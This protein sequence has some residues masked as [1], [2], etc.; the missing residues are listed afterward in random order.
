[1]R[2]CEHTGCDKPVFGTDK[3]TRTGYCKTHQYLR[4]DIDKDTIL[5][6][7][8]KKQRQGAAKSVGSKLRSGIAN[9]DTN[10]KMALEFKSKSELMIQAD[11]VFGDWIKERDKKSVFNEESG[12]EGYYIICP[13]CDKPYDMEEV[14][15]D[16]RKVVQPLHFV[17]RGVYSLRFDADNVFA[18]DSYCNL[19][20]HLSPKGREYHRY[21]KFLVN[22]FGEAAVK[23][24][25]LKKRDINKLSF[26]QLKNV[27][28]HYSPI[29]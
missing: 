26:E 23:E 12:T 29:K 7:A 19:R 8:I 5:Q 14:G 1:M 11:K 3:K 22:K 2:F 24:M 10:R 6:R 15:E 17:S 13:C 4:T 28:E 18:G 9:T 16:G 25:E 21:R 27:I 20:M